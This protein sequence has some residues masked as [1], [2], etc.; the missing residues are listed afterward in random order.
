MTLFAFPDEIRS[1][2]P[3]FSTN[4]QIGQS[5]LGYYSKTLNFCSRF[6][7]PYRFYPPRKGVIFHFQV[8]MSEFDP[9]FTQFD[10][11]EIQFVVSFF[12]IKPL[13]CQKFQSSFFEEPLAN[14]RLLIGKDLRIIVEACFVAIEH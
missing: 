7:R 5:F 11:R 3:I 14:S 1:Q 13:G 8:F 12:A 9:Q 10:S 2:F 4:E 6:G